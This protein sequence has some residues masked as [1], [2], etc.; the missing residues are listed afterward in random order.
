MRDLQEQKPVVLLV[1]DGKDIDLAD[2]AVDFDKKDLF[3]K[4]IVTEVGNAAMVEIKTIKGFHRDAVVGLGVVLV[5]NPH[6]SDR[7]KIFQRI[8]AWVHDQKAIPESTKEAFSLTLGRTIAN[9]CMG[10]SN[11]Q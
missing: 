6:L 4:V 8:E 9:G 11:I 10:Q 3:G 1:V 5:F 7:I 2:F